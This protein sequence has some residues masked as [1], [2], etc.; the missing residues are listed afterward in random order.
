MGSS[1]GKT[2]WLGALP[3]PR[4]FCRETPRLADYAKARI[5]LAAYSL[6]RWPDLATFV[7]TDR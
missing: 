5:C 4:P 2:G 1:G 3:G 7:R 6:V